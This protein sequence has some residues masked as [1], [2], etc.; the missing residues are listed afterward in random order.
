MEYTRSH[1]SDIK[2]IETV[3][4]NNNSGSLTAI[5]SNIFPEWSITRIFFINV[6]AAETRGNHA[7][8]ECIQA[9]ICVQGSLTIRCNDG[10][11]RKDYALKELGEI[12][13]VPPGIWVTLELAEN[14]SLAVFASHNYAEED[15]IRDM[16][17]FMKWR[18]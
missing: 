4:F 9:F 7:H 16:A 2:T 1:V 8:K 6:K 3:I 12:V 15:Y 5:E 11:S 10:S 17:S 14:S 18:R 13:V